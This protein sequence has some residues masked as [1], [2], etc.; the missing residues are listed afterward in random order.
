[1]SCSRQSALAITVLVLAASSSA[2]AKPGEQREWAI[3]DTGI[4]SSST[5]STS[6]AMK[7]GLAWPMI[8]TGSPVGPAYTLVPA[9]GTK[10]AAGSWQPLAAQPQFPQ[11]QRYRAIT[12]PDGRIALMPG[13]SGGA[14]YSAAGD[15][16]YLASDVQAVAFDRSGRLVTATREGVAGLPRYSGSNI[17]D[18]D[19]SPAGDIGIIDAT[20]RYWQYSPAVGKWL[21][22]SLSSVSPATIRAD[23]MDLE[24]DSFGRPHI[25]GSASSTIYAFDFSTITGTWQASMLSTMAGSSGLSSVTLVANDNGE[26]ATAW[27]AADTS[28]LMFA[29]KSDNGDWVTSLVAGDA[30]RSQRQL[31]LA[32]D[33]ADLPVISYIGSNGRVMLAYDPVAVPEPASFALLTLTGLIALR[34]NRAA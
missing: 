30:S 9:G 4:S 19:I 16:S 7:S 6:L 5:G 25:V 1:M 18:M 27:V 33:Y 13:S 32:Y 21:N 23:T 2:W 26:V 31:G 20:S 14:I 8:F 17:V 28:S 12:S 22:T 24:F 11:S 15:W 29:C 3:Q 10:A 34:R